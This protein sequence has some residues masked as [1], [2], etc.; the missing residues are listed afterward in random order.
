MLMGRANTLTGLN[1]FGKLA[2]VDK[3]KMSFQKMVGES[4][5][6]IIKKRGL[7]QKEVAEKLGITAIY[8]N[9]MLTGRSN[10]TLKKIEQIANILGV[11]P[12]EFFKVESQPS[13]SIS[14]EDYVLVPELQAVRAGIPNGIDGEIIDYKA[15]QERFIAKF[16]DPVLITVVGDSMEPYLFNGDL[17]LIDRAESAR[18]NITKKGIYLVR[19][20]YP[21]EDYSSTLTLKRVAYSPPKLFYVPTNPKYPIIE[22]DMSEDPNLLHYILGKVVWVGRE[23]K[24]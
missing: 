18:L 1:L 20:P 14:S 3:T 23:V 10:L 6:S 7:T 17:V 4:I 16:K 13:F 9:R 12:Y 24:D 11:S 21:G 2:F 19:L 22:V 5:A 15:F 8:L